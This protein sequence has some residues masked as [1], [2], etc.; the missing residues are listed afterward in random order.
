LV[1][2]QKLGRLVPGFVAHDAFNLAVELPVR[3]GASWESVPA[4]LLGGLLMGLAL[5]TVAQDANVDATVLGGGAQIEPLARR[6]WTVDLAVEVPAMLAGGVLLWRRQPLG[7]VA[8]AGLLFQY[9]L[10]PRAHGHPGPPA[11]LH[12]RALGH[13]HHRRRPGVRRG[14]LRGPW[15]FSHGT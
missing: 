10:T 11:R 7:Y 8:A 15:R 3:G 5:L 4:R 13:Q 14:L 9:G 12:Q 1:R 2:S 6:V